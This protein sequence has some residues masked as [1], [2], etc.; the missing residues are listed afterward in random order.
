MSKFRFPVIQ[1]L[2][3]GN[4]KDLNVFMPTETYFLRYAANFPTYCINNQDDSKFYLYQNYTDPQVPTDIFS[5]AENRGVYFHIIN[6]S[7]SWI[8]QD[9]D[10]FHQKEFQLTQ[11]PGEETVVMDCRIGPHEGDWHAAFDAYKKYI[12][13]TFDFKYYKRPVQQEYRK[14]FVS[15]FTFLYGHDI[16]NPETNEFEID[17]FFWILAS[18]IS[19]HQRS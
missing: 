18:S 17:R 11:E 12:Y 3:I 19:E 9:K 2:K 5:I 13:S 14:K 4:K 8:F 7:F 10:D 16:Y 6:T 15:H 1:D